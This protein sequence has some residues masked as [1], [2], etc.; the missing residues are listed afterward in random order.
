MTDSTSVVYVFPGKRRKIERHN[1]FME[2]KGKKG[3]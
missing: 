2:T 1:A 3:L